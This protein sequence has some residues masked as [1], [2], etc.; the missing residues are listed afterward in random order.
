LA[1]VRRR[2][3]QAPEESFPEAVWFIEKIRE[4]YRIEDR[5]RTLLPAERQVVRQQQA[6][7]IWEALPQRAEER[8]PQLLPK[9]TPGKA[10]NYFVNK[11]QALTDICA[12]G[13]FRST[14]TWWRRPSGR[15]PWGGDAGGL[16]AIPKRDGAA[17]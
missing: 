12:M 10:V 7:P 14:T 3:Y 5:V 1:H 11:Y 9:S 8:K 15:Q 16:L 4:L 6:P 2:F 17:R 13:A